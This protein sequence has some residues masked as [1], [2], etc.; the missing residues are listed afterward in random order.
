VSGDQTVNVDAHGARIEVSGDQT[1]NVDAHGARIEGSGDLIVNASIVLP[2]YV[3]RAL[4]AL[5]ILL[6]VLVSL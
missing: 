5:I 3:S 2:D 1:V 4:T 6:C